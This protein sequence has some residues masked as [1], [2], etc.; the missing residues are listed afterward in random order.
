M[1]ERDPQVPLLKVSIQSKEL[2][3]QSLLSEVTITTTWVE[4]KTTAILRNFTFASETIFC[5]KTNLMYGDRQ[6]FHETSHF[7]TA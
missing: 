6:F 7:F 4:G 5:I 2:K 3:S 1:N